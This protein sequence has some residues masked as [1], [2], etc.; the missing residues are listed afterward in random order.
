MEERIFIDQSAYPSEPQLKITLKSTYPHFQKLKT[1]TSQLAYEW[2][3]YSEKSGWVYK[4]HSHNKAL[5]YLTPLANKFQIGM[6]LDDSEKKILLESVID[7]QKKN[8]IKK[9]EKF[10][11]GYPLRFMVE[12]E[13]ELDQVVNVLNILNKI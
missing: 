9:A 10:P 11:E 6:T 4:V 2:K 7:D 1:L 5:F 8:E 12:T 13:N 3:Y